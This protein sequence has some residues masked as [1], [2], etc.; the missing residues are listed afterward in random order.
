MSQAVYRRKAILSRIRKALDA[1]YL[2][3]RIDWKYDLRDT[4]ERI[5]G[6]A[7][8]E[9]EFE[10]KKKIERALVIVQ[11]ED[12]NDLEVKAGWKIEEPDLSFSRTVV[13]QTID[14]GEAILCENAKD[15]PRF[16]EAE[17]IKDLQTLSLL[18]VPLQFEAQAIGAFYVESKSPGKFFD[19][20]D[21]EFLREFAE[22]TAPYLKTAI[23]HEDHVQEIR[24]L[25]EEV[26]DRYNLGNI[27]GRSESMANVFDLIRI[28]VDVDRTVLITGESGCGKELV[29][30]AIHHNG[31]RRKGNFV[32]VDCSTLAEHLLESELFGHRRGAFTGA[33]HHKMGAFEEADRGTLFLDEISDASKP[34]QQKLRRV[35]QE[36]EIRRVGE[37]TVRKVDVRV[38]C[39]TNRNLGELSRSGEF[40]RDL[41]Y[42]INKF[43]IQIPPLRDRPGDIPLLVNHFL[44]L[45]SGASGRQ[46]YT[47]EKDAMEF[48]ASRE[49]TEN[50]IRELRNTV[51]LAAD[52]TRGRNIDRSLL[53]RVLRI[54]EGK[55]RPEVQT[56]TAPTTEFNGIMVQ[57]HQEHFRRLL[58]SHQYVAREGKGEKAD[59]PYYRAQLEFNARIIIEGLRASGWKLR[60]AARVLGISPMKLRGELKEFL[61]ETL[62]DC[63]GD[64][65]TAANNLDIPVKLLEKKAA[66]LGLDEFLAGMTER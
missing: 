52:F 31:H 10:G 59:T 55:S 54:Q 37:N 6:L 23:T 39:A 28:A 36:G 45:A 58:D 17:S 56:R 27:I 8:E 2:L 51:E 16:M 49:W 9:I 13:Q 33:S 60:P 26:S 44:K 46:P 65:E 11:K 32:V 64:L 1:F 40:M 61:R 21:L 19:P 63:G 41:Y 7:L 66:D 50:N 4:L 43:P 24:K 47:I 14:R 25:K 20:D 5:M 22:T 30:K 35:L 38:I 34:L 12:G 3:Q 15:D 48:L 53:D 62:I 57:I 18:S 42:R 29:A